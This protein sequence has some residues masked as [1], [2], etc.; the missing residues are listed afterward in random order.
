MIKV[1]RGDRHD[2]FWTIPGV[3]LTG[4]LVKGLLVGA[5][6]VIPLQEL[7]LDTVDAAAGKVRH[8]LVGDLAPGEY[9]FEIEITRGEEVATAPTVGYETFIVEPDL[10]GGAP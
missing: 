7:A 5:A 8:R 9:Q 6:P 2:V 10:N 3:N 1:K 4:A